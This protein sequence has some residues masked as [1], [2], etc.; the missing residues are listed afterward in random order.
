M[1]DTTVLITNDSSYICMFEILNIIFK[2]I[3]CFK[4][5]KWAY[6]QLHTTGNPKVRYLKVKVIICGRKDYN[7]I[8]KSGIKQLIKSFFVLLFHIPKYLMQGR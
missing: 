6:L 2:K 5:K 4:N 8:E 1:T 3:L 7:C